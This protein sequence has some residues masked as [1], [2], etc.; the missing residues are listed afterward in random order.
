M[1]VTRHILPKSKLLQNTVTFG[2]K[3]PAALVLTTDGYD[4]KTYATY[5]GPHHGAGWVAAQRIKRQGI[6]LRVL[7]DSPPF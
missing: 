1:K 4:G 2:G 5:S 3:S 6:P 7:D